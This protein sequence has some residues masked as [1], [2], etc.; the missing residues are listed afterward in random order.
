MPSRTHTASVL[1]ASAGADV[2][3]RYR[4]RSGFAASAAKLE[5]AQR[6]GL[7]TD[8]ANN[9]DNPPLKHSAAFSRAAVFVVVARTT[10]AHF[11]MPPECGACFVDCLRTAGTLLF[12]QQGLSYAADHFINSGSWIVNKPFGATS[13]N[14]NP[15]SLR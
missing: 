10:Q 7:D 3:T 1:T 14:P 15:I 11:D 4:K 12:Y 6:R 2:V 5:S 9:A 8:N 13:N